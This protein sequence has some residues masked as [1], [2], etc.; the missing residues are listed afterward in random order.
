MQ[1]SPRAP[2][3]AVLTGVRNVN[4][5]LNGSELTFRLHEIVT[6]D[7]GGLSPAEI[8]AK[9]DTI[10]AEPA[11]KDSGTFTVEATDGVAAMTITRLW[12]AGASVEAIAKA[13]ELG[14]LPKK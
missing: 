1:V 8:R 3:S 12:L 7:V 10:C 4:I 9:V 2:A 5:S 6:V 11:V 14:L 13:M